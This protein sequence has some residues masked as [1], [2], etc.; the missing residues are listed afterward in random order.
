VLVIVSS[1]GTWEGR[2]ALKAG[3]SERSK[4]RRKRRRRRIKCGRK[5]AIVSHKRDKSYPR[6]HVSYG[7]NVGT[8]D[9]LEY[10]LIDTYR[11]LSNFR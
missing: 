6:T 8:A 9:C 2:D 1:L 3:K 4:R 5:F 11:A 10:R 7:W